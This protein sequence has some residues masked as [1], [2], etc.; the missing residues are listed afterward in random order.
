MSLL[1]TTCGQTQNVPF[2]HVPQKPSFIEFEKKMLFMEFS[3]G[4]KKSLGLFFPHHRAVGLVLE[5]RE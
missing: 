5:T 3:L 4:Q 1:V 2:R